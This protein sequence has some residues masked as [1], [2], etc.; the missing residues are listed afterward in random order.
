MVRFDTR[1]NNGI[2]SCYV[3]DVVRRTICCALLGMLFEGPA[4]SQVVPDSDVPIVVDYEAARLERVITAVGITGEI[5]IDGILDESAWGLATPAT[6]FVQR[7]PNPGAPSLERT[8]ARFLFDEDNLYIGVLCYDSDPENIVVNELEEDFGYVSG[9]VF[10]VAIDSL[11]N[12]Q[13]SVLFVT[14]PA[15]AKADFQ[16]GLTGFNTDWDGVWDV[17]VTRNSEGWIAEFVIPVQNSPVFQRHLAGVGN[18][19][20]SQYSSDQRRERLDSDSDSMGPVP[21]VAVRNPGRSREHP[22]PGVI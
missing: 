12:L 4:F 13:S 9:D 7:R 6:N 20:E 11:H 10:T 16:A 22:A 5:S 18:Q 19:H 17:Q 2:R 15:G 1:S 14:N 3:S 8:E 21:R